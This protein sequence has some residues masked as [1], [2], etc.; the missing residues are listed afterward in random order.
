M[1]D[2][3]QLVLLML[4]LNITQ[5][6]LEYKKNT[7]M[8]CLFANVHANCIFT[9]INLHTVSQLSVKEQVFLLKTKQIFSIKI[10]S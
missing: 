1:S 7:R 9:A 3:V 4:K 5:P 2:A 8:I 10:H 6:Q